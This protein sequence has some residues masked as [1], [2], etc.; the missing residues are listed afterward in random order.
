M[1]LRDC[2]YNYSFT[3]FYSSDAVILTCSEAD[4]VGIRRGTD[5]AA[6][7]HCIHHLTDLINISHLLA[8]I[9]RILL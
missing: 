4:R 9:E 7:L 1:F 5:Y 2:R 6:S 8:R 3:R